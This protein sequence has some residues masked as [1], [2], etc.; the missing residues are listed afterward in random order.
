MYLVGAPRDA[1]HLA[2]MEG[3]EIDE[4]LSFG[5]GFDGFPEITRLS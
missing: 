2:I 4:I 3:Q 1:L 5:S